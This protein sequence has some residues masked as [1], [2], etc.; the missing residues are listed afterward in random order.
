MAD[1]R[2]RAELLDARLD[3]VEPYWLEIRCACGVTK[4]CPLRLLARERGAQVRVN[5]VVR[6]LRCRKCVKAPTTV[7][8]TDDA[9]G[10]TPGLVGDRC[11]PWKVLLLP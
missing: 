9:T 7:A 5:D 6:R 4:F 2:S 3:E 1:Q 11:A 10:G 8:I